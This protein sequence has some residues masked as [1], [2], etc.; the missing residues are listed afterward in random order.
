M[1]HPDARS[2]PGKAQEDLRRRVVQA[3]RGELS[4]TH[5]ARLFG[6]ARGTVNRW[7]GLWQ[8]Q[9]A[10]ALK[11]RRRGRP[12]RSRLAPHQAA[13]TV[14]LIVSRCPNQL[15]LPFALW[16][17][18]AVQVAEA[19]WFDGS[20]CRSRSGRWA[21]RV[22]QTCG[23][24]HVCDH[25]NIRRHQE[26]MSAPPPQKAGGTGVRTESGRGA[27]SIVNPRRNSVIP[28]KG[29]QVRKHSTIP[30]KGGGWL[31][32]RPRSE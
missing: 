5:A 22:A 14:R 1:E 4:Q 30:K 6:V 24:W 28:S 17:R 2:L 31:G 11:A 10:A 18:E 29:A 8:R 25:P 3:V 20:V 27:A 23:V 19:T 15:R 7:M 21:A 26:A 9:R 32:L 12:P 13:T 16:M